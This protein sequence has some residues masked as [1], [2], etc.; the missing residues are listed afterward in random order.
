[1]VHGGG[2]IEDVSSTDARQRLAPTVWQSSVKWCVL[3]LG[4]RC[5]WNPVAP[6]RLLS[7]SSTTAKGAVVNRF[8]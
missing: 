8:H 6:A 7:L 2:G 1:M 3:L 5:P 4:L